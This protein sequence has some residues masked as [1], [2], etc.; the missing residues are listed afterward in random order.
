MRVVVTGASGVVGSCVVA[1]LVRRG[2][3]V[4]GL[5]R[6]PQ[7]VLPERCRHTRAD[8]RDAD[9]LIQVMTD[10]GEPAGAVVHLA[11][12]TCPSRDAGATHSVDVGGTRAVVGATQRAGVTRL[13]VMSS[14][15]AYGASVDTAGRSMVESDP[16]R[17]NPIH[18]YSLYKACA[19]E[20][21]ET[22]GVN[23]LLVRAATVL[24][25]YSTGVTQQRFAAPFLV[26]VKGTYN[27]LQFIHPDDVGRFVADAVLRPDWTG[28]VNLAA[29]DVIALRE[30]A[31]ILAK[32]YVELQPRRVEALLRL[33]WNRQPFSGD[34]GGP[35]PHYIA[36]W[37]T[38]PDLVNSGSCPR[39][40]AGT[41]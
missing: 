41:A 17:P 35:R 5:S 9:A 22:S 1:E 15:L 25:R 27:L 29:S 33:L 12:A 23:A 34:L 14:V 11:W 31:A 26:G 19:E 20:L 3:D 37:S 40:R 8:V 30:V 28:P 7:S 21:V 13:V 16:L 4:H 39:G 36:R 38:P 24:G 2:H 32:P 6:G 18:P 10:G